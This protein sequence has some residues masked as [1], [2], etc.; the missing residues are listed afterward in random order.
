MKIFGF[1][2]GENEEEGDENINN[3]NELSDNNTFSTLF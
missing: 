2:F 1:K 3:K